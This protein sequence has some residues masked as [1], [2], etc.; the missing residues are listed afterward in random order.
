MKKIF[1]LTGEP[2]G[3]KLASTVISKLKQRNPD[4]EYLCVG[5]TYLNSLG[6]K[7]I[8]DLK[9]ITYIAFTSVLLNIFKIRNR[10]NKTVDEVIKFNPDILFSVDSPDFSL[11]VSKIVKSKNPNIKT[12]H[13]IAPKVWAWRENRVK[14]MKKFLDHILLLFK[15]EKKYFNKENILNTFVGHPLLDEENNTYVKLDNLISNKKNIISLFAGSRESEIKIHAPILFK[16][17][18]KMNDKKKEFN[19]F[20][21]STNKFKNYLFNLLKKENIPNAEIIADDKIKNEVLQKSIFA[22]VKSGTVSLEVCKLNIPSI[23]FY[24]M[25]FINYCLAK[26]FL[27]IKFA[28][29]IN[30]IN[31]KEIIPELIQKD[32]NSDEIFRSVYYLLKKPEL[33]ENQLSNVKLTIEDLKSPSSSSEEASKILLSYLV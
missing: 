17:I 7:S 8:F 20:F 5:G 21:H 3:D 2:S 24:K 33:I 32:C 31:N 9:E 15:F 25:N 23:I 26:S 11:R 10:I 14:K 4:I 27:K 29:M 22:V 18:K 16:F 19:Y 6:I 1:I 12:I 13:F 28:N 30:I